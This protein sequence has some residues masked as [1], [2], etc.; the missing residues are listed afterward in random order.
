MREE[1]LYRG[2]KVY[3]AK[4]RLRPASTK[5][6]LIKMPVTLARIM[7]FEAQS[8]AYPKHDITGVILAGGRASR[9]GGIDKGLTPLSGKPMVAH[10]VSALRPQVG[11]LI[12]NANRNLDEYAELGH[13]VVPDMLGEYF[14]PLAGIATGMQNATTRYVLTAPC[15][16]PLLAADLG[17][18][19]YNALER[20]DKE[21]SV[22]HDGNRL[23][24]VFVLLRRDLLPSLLEFLH[25][26]E[27]KIDR[28]FARHEVSVADFSNSP[29]TFINVNNPEERDA[30]EADMQ[31]AD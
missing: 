17:A 16:S 1:L 23:H 28:W 26:G 15:D 7:D 12:I 18:R 8:V 31:K 24:P 10:V 21:M 11:R 19:L 25:S 3:G 30:L 4:S 13:R 14:G 9:M 22:A 6:D 29:E 5:C 20:E 27:R 2:A